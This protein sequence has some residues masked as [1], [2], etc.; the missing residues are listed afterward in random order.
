[1]FTATLADF[2]L[3]LN[4]ALF[5]LTAAAIW[6][7]GSRLAVAADIIADRTGLG[8][9]LVGL[10]LLAT[11]TS[12]PEVARTIAASALGNAPL[13]VNALFGGV[14][15]QTAILAVADLLVASRVLTYFA[16]QP[17]LL[18]QGTFVVL[19]LAL[20]LAAIAAGE[21]VPLFHVGLW[22]ILLLA[23]YLFSLH[24]LKSYGREE[25]WRPVH[26]PP[27]LKAEADDRSS[28]RAHRRQQPLSRIIL[29]FAL[30]SAVIL[31]CGVLLAAV[32]DVL[33]VQTGLGAG[34]VGATLLALAA[35][36]PELS[37]TIAAV[38]FGAYS[39]AV[40]N[41]FGTNAQL[42][43]L[44]FLADLFYRPGPV[45]VALGPSAAFAAAMGI[46]ATAIYLLG[47]L[48]RRNRA[49]LGMGIDSLAVLLLYV[50]SLIVMYGLR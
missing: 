23:L 16:P 27:E 46:V 5:L 37:T 25:H 45:L 20:A 3:W 31:V 43:A 1:M 50:A 39:M 34:F 10:V 47:L 9:A 12:L 24:A 41:I 32:G 13:A 42:V 7:A 33:A 49:L 44:L 17:V 48:E 8:E 40:S 4:L 14:L 22:T 29:S 36:L 28:R 6:L 18:L 21:L 30:Q 2:P 35:G 15:V 26:V 19:L 38:R 11:A